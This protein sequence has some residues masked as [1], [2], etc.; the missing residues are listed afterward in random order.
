MRLSELAQ[1]TSSIR[2]EADFWVA[3][4]LV[5]PGKIM[6]L[7][8]Y[9]S[10]R[11]EWLEAFKEFY[12]GTY[13]GGPGGVGLDANY[14]KLKATLNLP[15]VL[16]GELEKDLVATSQRMFELKFEELVG[17]HYK[18]QDTF[19]IAGGCA[20]NILN[21]QRLRNEQGYYT[22][23]GHYRNMTESHKLEK[24]SMCYN[25]MCRIIPSGCV[26]KIYEY[27]TRVVCKNM[28]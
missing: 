10:V 21:N 17:K 24:K 15:D 3:G 20:L 1:Y 23:L 27:Y 7:S 13:E 16:E 14:L 9:G 4:G 26:E 25:Q 28:F 22:V 12:T 8:S 19:I 18:D 6:G 11:E 5:Y 2:K